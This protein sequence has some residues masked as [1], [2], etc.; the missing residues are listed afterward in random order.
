MEVASSTATMII[1]IEIT[2]ILVAIR[3]R[4]VCSESACS[5]VMATWMDL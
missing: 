3:A 1:T 2:I 5:V 4:E